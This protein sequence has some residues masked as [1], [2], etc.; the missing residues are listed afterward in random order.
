MRSAIFITLILALC[1]YS[2]FGQARIQEEN[3]KAPGVE[4]NLMSMQATNG[5][6]PLT[7]LE[8]IIIDP[9]PMW[10]K[11]KVLAKKLGLV[12][13]PEKQGPEPGN[14]FRRIFFELPKIEDPRNEVG[15]KIR[16]E[17]A[18]ISS[19]PLNGV[20]PPP[21]AP[22][23]QAAKQ[24]KKPMKKHSKATGL[25]AQRGPD[26]QAAHRSPQATN[27]GPSAAAVQAP[28]QTLTQ[29]PSPEPAKVK[30]F[31]PPP[32]AAKQAKKPMKKVSKATG[33]K[34]QRGPDP[35]AAH[36]SPQATNN[37]PSAAAVQAPPQPPPQAPPPEV[38]KQA[39][40]FKKPTNKVSKATGLKTR[41]ARQQ[42][43]V[44]RTNI[45]YY[46]TD[47]I[48]EPPKAPPPEA[49]KS[50]PMPPPKPEAGKAVDPSTLLEPVGKEIFSFD[51]ES[52]TGDPFC[53]GI[54]FD[55]K[56]FWVTGDSINGMPMLY[57]ISRDGALINLYPQPP[58]NRN[59]NSW[60]DLAYDGQYLYAV[61]NSEGQAKI[62]Q[63]EPITGMTTGTFIRVP[64]QTVSAVAFDPATQS[65]WTAAEY[66]DIYNLAMDGTVLGQYPNFLCKVSS[67]AMEESCDTGRKLWI[68]SRDFGPD[69]NLAY[70]F[71]AAT[72]KFTGTCFEGMEPG[73][74]QATGACAYN[75]FK[76]TGRWV[77]ATLFSES[78]NMIKGYKLAV[79][80][81][82]TEI[83]HYGEAGA[84]WL[85]SPNLE[86]VN[87]C[88]H[89]ATSVRLTSSSPN[90][91]VGLLVFGLAP[92]CTPLGS[93][94]CKLLVDVRQS[95]PIV[96]TPGES[97]YCSICPEELWLIETYWQLIQTDPAGQ[98]FL[99][100]HIAV[101]DGV[102]V[103]IGGPAY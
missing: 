71:D 9:P 75:D 19:P 91:E 52:I 6:K 49:V 103:F 99:G 11:I 60:G 69:I 88:A 12:I 25:K 22:P 1:C 32:E 95:V 21:Q 39:K 51:L 65:F 59:G 101:S 100:A 50:S 93:T 94:D 80:D 74:G 66:S 86:F 40:P 30:P 28:P 83:T 98:V 55:G 10:P 97:E 67:M 92:C 87:A 27:N 29:A 14:A 48:A 16:P 38:A 13:R 2:S 73:S 7:F 41:K 61:D 77:M 72:G 81:P 15:N 33:L 53:K 82:I 84:G 45:E 78:P 56:A 5:A 76:G 102:K 70:Q 31:P 36:R 54:E 58:Q 4:E 68:W 63:I 24:A 96:L 37:G 23:P 17:I 64:M 46:P 89:A 26:P 20:K 18:E 62:T 44:G 47:G 90:Q 42:P 79:A 35:Q 43:K 8:R 57:K 85:G 34:A 3:E